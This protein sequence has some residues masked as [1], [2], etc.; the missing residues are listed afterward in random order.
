MH[1][2]FTAP[3]GRLDGW[4]ASGVAGDEN[5]V[6]PKPAF[7]GLRQRPRQRRATAF[8][9]GRTHLVAAFG[10][11]AA[12]AVSCGRSR[13]L[14]AASTRDFSAGEGAP[15][16]NMRCS[17]KPPTPERSV[18]DDVRRA[19]LDT[20]ACA[21]SSA[22]LG[23]AAAFLQSAREM[24]SFACADRKAGRTKSMCGKRVRWKFEAR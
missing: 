2:A 24:K 21:S 23:R 13:A 17:R 12:W 6:V 20:Q 22:M 18:L 16:L 15:S 14:A 3:R 5:F 1:H 9:C 19:S 8:G 7:T 4:R 10:L 11:E